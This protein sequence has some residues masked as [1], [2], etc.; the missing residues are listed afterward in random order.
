[1][2]ADSVYGNH[3][4]RGGGMLNAGKLNSVAMLLV[5]A[6]VALWATSKVV[7]RV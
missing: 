5:F 7:S 1:M 3:G 6:G 4:K 2:D